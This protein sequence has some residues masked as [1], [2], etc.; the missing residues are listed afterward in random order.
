[1][2]QL[3]YVV[4]DN[5]KQAKAHFGDLN[6]FCLRVVKDPIHVKGLRGSGIT[7]NVLPTVTFS[8]HQ[9]LE[10]AEA[11]GLKIHFL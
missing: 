11:Q 2:S 7:L 3:V 4:A 10:E 9:V 6:P 5:W 1:M 8:A